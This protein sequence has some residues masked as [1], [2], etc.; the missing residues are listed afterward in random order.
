MYHAAYARLNKGVSFARVERMIAALEA[1][2]CRVRFDRDNGWLNIDIPDE[3]MWWVL[4]GCITVFFEKFKDVADWSFQFA[5][6]S[7]EANLPLEA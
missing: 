2:E 1:Q 7:T 5:P 4:T 6:P 3:K